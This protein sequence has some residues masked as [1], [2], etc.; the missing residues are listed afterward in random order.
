MNVL[1]ISGSTREQ[2]YNTALLRNMG[3]L[4]L[5]DMS[6]TLYPSLHA[7]PNYNPM[8]AGND[9]PDAVED[10]RTSLRS[11]DA[12]VLA[13][14]EYAYG[15]PGILKNALDWV[16]ASGELVMKPVMLASVSTSEL[17]GARAHHALL[18]VLHA[19]NAKIVINASLNVPFA[20]EKF[21]KQG[22]LQDP[23]LVQAL[24]TNL[25]ILAQ[26]VQ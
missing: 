18:T 8:L 15:I 9:M 22:T 1:G 13:T 16:V 20:S 25:Q 17:G 11:A 23:L 6:F 19:M 21:S 2:S 26:A 3:T 10:F 5:D 14:P 4:G 12:V 24:K 7:I